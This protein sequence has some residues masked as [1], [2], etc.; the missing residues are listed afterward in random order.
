LINSNELFKKIKS[1]LKVVFTQNRSL[2]SLIPGHVVITLE[3]LSPY[4]DSKLYSYVADGNLVER[5]FI[6]IIAPERE[7][8][9]KLV[10]M[11]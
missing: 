7:G 11:I 10:E 9:Y 6:S 2:K 3:K 5:K 1:F 8:K 4:P